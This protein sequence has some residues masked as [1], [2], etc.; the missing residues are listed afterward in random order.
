MQSKAKQS[1]AKAKQSKAKQSK[2][3][4]FKERKNKA[5]QTQSKAKAKRKP[6]NWGRAGFIYIVIYLFCFEGVVKLT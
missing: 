1:R 3:K 4:Q 6:P 5:R 2:T